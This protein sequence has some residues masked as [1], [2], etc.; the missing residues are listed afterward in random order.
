VHVRAEASDQGIAFSVRDTGI[1]IAAGDVPVIFEM[2]RQLD[3]SPARAFEGV[4]LGLHIVARL[5]A[6]L[7]GRVSVDSAPGRGST[8]T[9]ELPLFERPAAE[10]P[11]FTGHAVPAA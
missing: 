10:E 9:V 3:S 6:L 5:T 11:G 4:G 7:G 8:F 2:F 1:G